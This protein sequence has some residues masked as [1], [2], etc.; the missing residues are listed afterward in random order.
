MMSERRSGIIIIGIIAIASLGL[1]GYMFLKNEILFPITIESNDVYYCASSSEVQSAIDTIGKGSGEIIM[2]QDFSISTSINVNGEGSYI[3]RG[4]KG[5]TLTILSELEVFNITKAKNCILQDFTIDASQLETITTAIIYIQEA[6]DN[7]VIIDN[8]QLIGDDEGIGYG[9]VIESDY[10]TVQNCIVNGINR[11]FEIGSTINYCLI[12]NNYVSHLS[13]Y[14][15]SMHWN[16]GDYHVIEGN[17]L[18]YIRIGILISS[19]YSTIGNNLIIRNGD[20]GIWI[21]G[22]SYNA[23]TGNVINYDDSISSTINI[24]GIAINYNADYNIVSGNTISYIFNG[25]TGMGIG[26]AY[27]SFDCSGNEL[28]NNVLYGNE[29]NTIQTSVT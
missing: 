29:E 25:D 24:Y 14:G 16:C 28:D 3:I 2:T 5:T 27:D 4:L 19:R 23:L 26:M 13:G 21:Y 18:Q 10:V 9:I 8:V 1:T 15:I 7:P 12:V 20:R 22:G 11:G 6:S 17:T